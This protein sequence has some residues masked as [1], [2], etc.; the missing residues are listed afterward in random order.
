MVK[1]LANITRKDLYGLSFY[2]IEVSRLYAVPHNKYVKKR[3]LIS[4]LSL[5]MVRCL[6]TLFLNGILSVEKIAINFVYFFNVL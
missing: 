2:T 1:K 3:K 4:K 5:C 6:C